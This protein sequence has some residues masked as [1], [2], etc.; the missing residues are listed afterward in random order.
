MNRFSC[1]YRIVK[2]LL[3]A[4]L[5]LGA[6]VVP[7]A[8]AQAQTQTQASQQNE[9]QLCESDCVV[10]YFGKVDSRDTLVYGIFH[11]ADMPRLAALMKGETESKVDLPDSDEELIKL[12]QQMASQDQSGNSGKRKQPATDFS[13]PAQQKKKAEIE[14]QRKKALK[15]LDM[16][17]ASADK[18]K[19]VKEINAAFDKML[20]DLPGIYSD[21]QKAGAEAE[22]SASAPS[23]ALTP[24]QKE[25]LK[26]DIGYTTLSPGQRYAIKKKAAALA[27]GG[28][29]WR[30]ARKFRWGRAAV[31]TL[32]D[33]RERWGFMDLS[34]RLVVPC[35]YWN[36][37][38]F[39]N[40]RARSGGV[41]DR[42]E[43][44]DTR[45]WTSVTDEKHRMGMI[46]AN[47][48]EVIPCKF[49]PHSSGYD[50][51]VFRKTPWGEYAPVQEDASRKYGIIDRS[52]NYTLPPTYDGII[53]YEGDLQCFSYFNSAKTERIYFDHQGNKIDIKRQKEK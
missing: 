21:G 29:L 8:T 42:Q 33:G 39:K 41:F 28:R 13:A 36:V 16:L 6:S 25:S 20:A 7:V 3:P 9:Q 23:P 5:F 31:S 50:L 37:Q 4:V 22:K 27:I 53:H 2:M 52:G 47:G 30:S 38:D 10:H 26:Q 19:T 24:D 45:M 40:R 43:D 14:A 48:R 44:Q 46:D 11:K 15:Q 1:K 12:A 34:G 35:K 51:L 18:Q 49:V 17:P 32:V